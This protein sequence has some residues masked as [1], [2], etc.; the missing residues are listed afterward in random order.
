MKVRHSLCR[1]SNPQQAVSRTTSIPH[2]SM[3]SVPL[4][5][6]E[7]GFLYNCISMRM[8]YSIVRSEHRSMQLMC[9]DPNY[10][11]VLLALNSRLLLVAHA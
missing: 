8:L 5:S 9:S 6:T 3:S 1:D 4:V 7:L 2:C 10:I 11:A